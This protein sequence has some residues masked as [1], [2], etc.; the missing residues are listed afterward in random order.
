M[1]QEECMQVAVA[2]VEDASFKPSGHPVYAYATAVR[3]FNVS[4]RTLRSQVHGTRPCHEA[5]T[6]QCKLSKMAEEVL[7]AWIKEL[8]QHGVPLSL[9]A[10]LSHVQNLA[11][12]GVPVGASWLK[13]FR[14]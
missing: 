10:V 1:D 2:A 3:D 12:S 13:Q 8:R 7:V 11:P 9:A 5:D 4:C 6:G 14:S